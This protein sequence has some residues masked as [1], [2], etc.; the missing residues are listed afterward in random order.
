[1]EDPMPQWKR[2]RGAVLAASVAV[3]VG[4][5]GAGDPTGPSPEPSIS[6]R[7]ADPAPAGAGCVRL[8]A[9]SGAGQ[10][11]T[12][13]YLITFPRQ[14]PPSVQCSLGPLP[15]ALPHGGLAPRRALTGKPQFLTWGRLWSF[16]VTAPPDLSRY[17]V[18]Y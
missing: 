14:A 16:D 12:S 7:P 13:G 10:I 15:H 9:P 11:G 18:A 17:A 1:M 5:S 4:C 8:V 6:A 3:T 2:F